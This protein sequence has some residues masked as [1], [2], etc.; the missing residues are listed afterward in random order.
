MDK[1]DNLNINTLSD[2]DKGVYIKDIK[3]KGVYIKNELIASTDIIWTQLFSSLT[4]NLVDKYLRNVNGC[5]ILNFSSSRI[6]LRRNGISDSF[7]E[8]YTLDQFTVP[9]SEDNFSLHRNGSSRIRY[10]QI[11]FAS[12]ANTS[13]NLFFIK[14]GI[15]IDGGS[16]AKIVDVTVNGPD[17]V[18]Y[19]GF[20]VV[21]LLFDDKP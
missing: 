2:N 1:I 20:N 6:N 3:T 19:R 11:T 5:A 21:I 10:I 15:H 9:K 8:P 4:N 18:G 12:Y 7:Y 16:D 14:N 13:L 17:S